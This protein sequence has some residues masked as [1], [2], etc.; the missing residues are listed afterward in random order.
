MLGF[1]VQSSYSRG[2]DSRCRVQDLECRVQ[3]SGFWVLG[4][5]FMG[6]GPGSLSGV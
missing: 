5:E 4:L 3:G 2:L 6:Q 1:L